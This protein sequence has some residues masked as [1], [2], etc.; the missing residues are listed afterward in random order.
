MDASNSVCKFMSRSYFKIPS[1]VPKQFNVPD[2]ELS[3]PN[4]LH[5]EF[6]VRFSDIKQIDIDNNFQQPIHHKSRGS[7]FTFAMEIIDLQHV[8]R[9]RNCEI[10]GI[11]VNKAICE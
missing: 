9:L 6:E 11:E 1:I 10:T 3:V 5:V 4:T 8:N 2:R 7:A